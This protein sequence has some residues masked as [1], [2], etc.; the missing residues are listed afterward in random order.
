[1]STN[2][3]RD[4]SSIL[5]RNSGLTSKL[6]LMVFSVD[7]RASLMILPLMFNLNM[8]MLYIFAGT[9]IFF[10]VL[11]FL[12]Y[13]VPVSISKVRSIAAGKRRNTQSV[14]LNRRRMIHG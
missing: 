4:Y 9:M 14:T 7:A 2:K 13:T 12:G 5:W 1:M 8:T 10:A 3:I 11:E 6:G